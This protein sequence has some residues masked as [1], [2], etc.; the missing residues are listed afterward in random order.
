LAV[1]SFDFDRARVARDF[2]LVLLP[3]LDFVVVDMAVGPLALTR[4]ALCRVRD[5]RE[6]GFTSSCASRPGSRKSGRETVTR[7]GIFSVYSVY[8]EHLEH[9]FRLY[10]QRAR[11]T[12]FNKNRFFRLFLGQLK[13]S[14]FHKLLIR[15][16]LREF[17]KFLLLAVFGQSGPETGT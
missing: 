4:D 15:I 17:S 6:F 14:L 12:K 1:D 9:L 10:Y 8:A 7:G 2:A 3:V 16:D 5:G 11:G 13:S